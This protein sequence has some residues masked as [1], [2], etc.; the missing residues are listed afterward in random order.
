MAKDR[1]KTDLLALVAFDNATYER[2]A[3]TSLTA[4]S[5]FWLQE[6]GIGAALNNVA[7]LNY[8][9]FPLKFALVGWPQFPDV[10]RTSRSILQMRP[11]YRNLATSATDKGV[12]LNPNGMREAQA[13]IEQLGAPRIAEEA[14]QEQP[15]VLIKAERGGRARSVHPEDLLAQVQKSQL[16]EIYS[17]SRFDEAE[18]IHLIEMLGV[19]DHTPSSEKK[20]KLKEFKDAAKELADQQVEQFIDAAFEKFQKYLSR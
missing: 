16:F 17:E 4:Y 8:K 5:V 20:R 15:T 6:W 11:K 12:F 18:A 19:Y 13:L 9:L 1:A 2:Y 7:V 3:L 14:Q 10:N